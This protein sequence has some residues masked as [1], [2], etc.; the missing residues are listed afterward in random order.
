MARILL[1]PGRT[2]ITLEMARQLQRQGH[3]LFV[4]DTT[5]ISVAGFSNVIKKNFFLPSP[6]Y[7][8]E[9]FFH[10]LAKIIEDNEIE[11][12]LP[13][14]EEILYIAKF[15][16]SLPENCE[17]F[18]DEFDLLHTLHHKW[19]FIELQ[20]KINF[21]AP[22]TELIHST[23]DLKKLDR[24]KTWIFKLSYS[25]AAQNMHKMGPNDPFPA[26]RYQESN[27]WIAQ[28]WLTGNKYCSYSIAK[29]GKLQAHALY[30]IKFAIDD[31]SCLNFFAITHPKI[32]TWVKTFV[33][34]TC[35]TGQIAFD[36]IETPEDELFAIECNPRG[37][38]GIH[39]FQA[40]DKLDRAFFTDLEEPIFPQKDFSKQILTGMLLYGWKNKPIPAFFKQIF[41]SPDVIYDKKDIAPFLLQPMLLF[42]YL[43]WCAKYR[44]SLPEA[45]T[46]D[47]N[48]NG[49]ESQTNCKILS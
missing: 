29:K 16:K 42:N 10:K 17:I 2:P 6:R 26:L 18:A 12:F 49:S 28:K 32:L 3:T 7:Q 4:A 15:R 48:W 20:K 35:F 33:E 22:Q 39:L 8:T 24:E 46:Y 36:F 19:L 40:T 11:F 38:S 5:R 31:S 37:T 34:K 23:E 44:T 9:T 14:W 45:F 30:P 43:R 27:P 25:R 47:L 21:P 41:T 13:M 1:T